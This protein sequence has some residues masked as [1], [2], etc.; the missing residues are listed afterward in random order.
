V[1]PTAVGVAAATSANQSKANDAE[2]TEF[3]DDDFEDFEKMA[4]GEEIDPG[5]DSFD[6]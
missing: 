1:V 6:S 2:S 5:K 3:T 4:S